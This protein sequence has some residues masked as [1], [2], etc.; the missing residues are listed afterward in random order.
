[1]KRALEQDQVV[2][3]EYLK[4]VVRL[5]IGSLVYTYPNFTLH[6]APVGFVNMI[7]WGSFPMAYELLFPGQTWPAH[8]EKKNSALFLDALFLTAVKNSITA[9]YGSFEV[10]IY[11]HIQGTHRA[12]GVI[13]RDQRAEQPLLSVN[14]AEMARTVIEAIQAA[15]TPLILVQRQG[16]GLRYHNIWDEAKSEFN[17]KSQVGK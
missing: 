9:H 11:L 17:L 4:M 13:E 14:E 7:E 6:H 1:M 8:V 5:E 10:Q 16:L 15:K 12:L 3:K 2:Y